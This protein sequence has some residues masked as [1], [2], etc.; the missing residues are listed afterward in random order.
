[1]NNKVC[2]LSKEKYSVITHKTGVKIIVCEKEDYASTYA[3]FASKYG[4]NNTVCKVINSDKVIKIP[5]GTAHFLEH[6][7]FEN[8]NEDAFTLY[9][10]TGADAN[11]YTTFDKTAYLFSCTDNFEE[12]FEILLNFVQAPYFTEKSVAKEQGI[13]GQEIKMYEDNPGSRVFWDLMKNLFVNNSAAIDTAGTVESIADITPELLYDCY[14]TFYNPENM[15]I[16]VCGCIAPQKVLELC[17]KLLKPKTAEP[18]KPEIFDEPFSVKCQRSETELA[19]DIP[20]FAVGY[21]DSF[22]TIG[23]DAVKSAAQTDI[24]LELLAGK[25]S[26]LYNELYKS[27]DIN[28]GFD[29]EYMYGNG[30]GASIFTGISNNPD[31]IYERIL[32]YVNKLKQTGVDND[33]FERAKKLIFGKNIRNLN[34]IDYTANKM[35]DLAVMDVDFEKYMQ[36]YSGVTIDDCV[37]RLNKHFCDEASAISIIKPYT[38]EN[39]K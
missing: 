5:D 13:I 14:N 30:F 32:F 20:L 28:S 23:E 4:S 36:I 22:G 24:L 34:S 1:M 17:D 3:I 12:S 33:K 31:K 15:V 6:K 38:K 27:G 2:S 9:A 26:E 18:V 19:V 21:K 8:E 11:A 16:I 25:S 35:L 37:E 7:L 29:F 39:K 10:K